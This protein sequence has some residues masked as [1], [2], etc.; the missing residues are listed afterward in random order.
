M[1]ADRETEQDIGGKYV[2]CF[3]RKQMIA[4]SLAEEKHKTY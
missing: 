1:T 3:W 2:R 4:T